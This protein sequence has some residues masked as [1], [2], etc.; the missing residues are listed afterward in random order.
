MWFSGFQACTLRKKSTFIFVCGYVYTCG[1]E[2]VPMLLNVE[3]IGSCWVASSLTSI[4]VGD[5]GLNWLAIEFSASPVL[6]LLGWHPCLSFMWMMGIQTQ[7]PRRGQQTLTEPPL[8]PPKCLTNTILVEL[9]EP[10]N[11]CYVC[12]QLL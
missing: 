6:Q 8:Q 5:L 9:Y 3:A 1:Q 2:R 7:V 12:H 11:N 4:S 10:Q